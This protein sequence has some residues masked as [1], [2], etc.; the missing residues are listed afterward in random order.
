MTATDILRLVVVG[1]GF[2]LAMSGLA[3][4]VVEIRHDA[5][6]GCLPTVLVLAGLA[7]IVGGGL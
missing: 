7:L 5:E 3:V 6:H 4:R 2:L 1:I